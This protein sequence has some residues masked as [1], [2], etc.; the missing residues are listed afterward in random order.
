M[1]WLAISITLALFACS[2]VENT[3]AIE[4]EEQAVVE[5]TLLLCGEETPLRRIGGRLSVSKTIDCEGSGRIILRYASGSEQ[6]CTVGYVTPGA[7]QSFTYRATD[8]GCT[9]WNHFVS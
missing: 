3:F 5:A 4:D 2:K 1:K 9:T 8:K 7:V 6:I